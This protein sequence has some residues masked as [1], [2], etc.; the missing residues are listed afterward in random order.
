ASRVL[1]RAAG[2]V[3]G[4]LLFA[5]FAAVLPHPGGLIALVAVSGALIP[6]AAR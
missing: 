1:N 3:L 6:V 2:T 4:A 5:G